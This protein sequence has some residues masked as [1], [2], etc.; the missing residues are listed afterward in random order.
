MAHFNR[1][2][3][4][5]NSG[6]S[7]MSRATQASVEARVGHG[8]SIGSPPA[9]YALIKLKRPLRRRISHL[10]HQA[11]LLTENDDIMFPVERHSA[12]YGYF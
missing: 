1:K 3:S 8:R 11:L 6:T 7:R 5:S 9:W 2:K 10:S 12:A 4:R